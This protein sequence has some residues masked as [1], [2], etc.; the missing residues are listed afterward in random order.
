MF[1]TLI[2]STMMSLWASPGATGVVVCH[3]AESIHYWGQLLKLF[4]TKHTWLPRTDD[5]EVM[6]KK[7]IF[8]DFPLVFFNAKNK[9]ILL[10]YLVTAGG[11]TRMQSNLLA[12]KVSQMCF[13]KW[14]SSLYRGDF[15]CLMTLS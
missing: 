13:T 9:L 6:E 11:I 3:E 14:T 1:V 2:M 8:S 12:F 7:I 15:T 10:L 4:S 5:E